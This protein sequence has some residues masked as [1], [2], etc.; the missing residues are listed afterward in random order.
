MLAGFYDDNDS[1]K[2]VDLYDLTC[3]LKAMREYTDAI[4]LFKEA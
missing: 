4:K 1:Q 3:D 2:S